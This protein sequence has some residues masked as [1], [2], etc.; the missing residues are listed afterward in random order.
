MVFK[1][2]VTAKLRNKDGDLLEVIPVNG[3]EL[4]P[5]ETKNVTCESTVDI[6]NAYSYRIN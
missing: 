5:G 3:P 2:E 6:T 4:E 1:K